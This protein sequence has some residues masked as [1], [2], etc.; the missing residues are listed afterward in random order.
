MQIIITLNISS[1]FNLIKIITM[2]TKYKPKILVFNLK[3]YIA[4]AIIR[5]SRE[6]PPLHFF[7]NLS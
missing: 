2:Y 7:P 6:A 3:I 5:W 1:K 4:S